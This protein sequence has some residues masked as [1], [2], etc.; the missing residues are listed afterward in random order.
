MAKDKKLPEVKPEEAP[1]DSSGMTD[2]QRLVY[3]LAMKNNR[4]NFKEEDKKRKAGPRWRKM[5]QPL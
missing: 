5:I 1:T 4:R 2:A 3:A